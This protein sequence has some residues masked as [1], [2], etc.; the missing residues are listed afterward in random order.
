MRLYDT[1]TSSFTTM[2]ISNIAALIQRGRRTYENAN[3][4]LIEYSTSDNV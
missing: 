3:D 1:E 2:R 4:V